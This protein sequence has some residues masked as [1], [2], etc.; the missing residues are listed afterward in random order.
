MARNTTSSGG[1]FRVVVVIEWDDATTTTRYYG[2]YDGLGTARGVKTYKT[3][4]RYFADYTRWNPPAPK[5]VRA[6]GHVEQATAWA[7]AE[8]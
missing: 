5:P 3:D 2:P 1:A 6:T 7:K 4:P 8:Q